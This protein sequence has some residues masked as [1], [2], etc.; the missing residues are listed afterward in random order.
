MPCCLKAASEVAA[1]TEVTEDELL[2]T[3][4]TPQHVLRLAVT[5]RNPPAV[6]ECERL[7]QLAECAPHVVPLR[8]I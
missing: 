1:E 5:V 7:K 2:T 8:R 4:I 3:L 6:A